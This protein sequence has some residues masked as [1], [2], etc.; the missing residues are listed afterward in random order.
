MLAFKYGAVG[1]KII[2]PRFLNPN[3]DDNYS[4]HACESPDNATLV[5]I[6]NKE[7]TKNFS[8]TIQLSKTASNI[9]V[10]RLSAP[11]ITANTEVTFAGSTVN[12][13]GSFEPANPEEYRTNQ[14][15]L[16]VTVP[17]GSAAVVTVK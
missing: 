7:T 13:D 14:K 6:I 9:Q 17:A 2:Q 12:S 16:T 5:T 4:V 8:F 15:S 10:A 1:N 3:P 11:S